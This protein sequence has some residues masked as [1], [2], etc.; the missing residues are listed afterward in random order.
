MARQAKTNLR[1]K[2]ARLR[3]RPR[4]EP[5]YWSITPG[6]TLGYVR[7]DGVAGS[8]LTR[9]RAEG[10]AYG[11]NTFATADDFTVAAPPDVLTF[12][13][14]LAEAT[15]A[16]IPAAA[17]HLTVKQALDAYFVWFGGRSEH[18]KVTKQ[19]ADARIVPV[20]GRHRV[21]RLT[22]P[23]IEAWQAGL[24]RE[25]PDDPDV[26][27]RSQDTANRLLTILKAAL[28]KAFQDEV[29]AIPTDSA[30]RRVKPFRNV[31]RARTEHFESSQVRVLVSK[32][33][34]FDPRFADLVEVAYL[35]GARLGELAAAN[36]RDFNADN[37]TLQVDGK[38][39]PRVVTLTG[40][41]IALF[42]RITAKRP[43]TDPLLPRADGKRW[44]NTQHRP[45]Q[46]ALTLAELPTG[47]SFYTLRH[48]YVSRAIEAGM[49]LSL[50][51]ENVGTSLT[52]IERNYAHV[53]QHRRRDMIE[54]TAP[55][56]RRVK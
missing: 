7:R 34:T 51:A 45:M 52:M 30:W 33:R 50:I 10:A 56:L 1:T 2:T 18:A 29:N 49:P 36:V 20:L 8:W 47:A 5:Y 32:A 37:G 4:K 35:S 9:E 16:T 3:L 21:D 12:E 44:T 53:L 55:R 15:K 54:A 31:G 19:W 43:S 39:G 6:K 41:C 28:N 48:S 38:T 11:Y 14:A 27:R 25:D 17:G 13:Q 24:L 26:R 22:T 23:Q 40:E 42:R 46:R